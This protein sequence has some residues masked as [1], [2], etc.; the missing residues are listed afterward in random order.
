MGLTEKRAR[1]LGRKL[2]IGKFPFSASGRALAAGE[3]DGFVKL[4]FDDAEGELLGVHMIGEG[5]TEMLSELVMAKKLEA[6]EDEIIEAIHPH[7]TFSEAIME[8][9]GVADGRAIHL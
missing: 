6:T 7:P 5:V 1:A 9:A 4:I 2:K 8:A 3:P